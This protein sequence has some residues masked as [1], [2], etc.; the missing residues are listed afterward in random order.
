ML[1]HQLVEDM[2]QGLNDSYPERRPVPQVWANHSLLLLVV[3][4]FASLMAAAAQYP[5]GGMVTV[6]KA[7][8]TTVPV[9]R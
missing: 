1:P 8:A 4:L 7:N 6:P 9:G 2:S 5:P 3:L